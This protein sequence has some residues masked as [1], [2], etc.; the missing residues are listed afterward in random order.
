[1]DEIRQGLWFLEESLWDAA[2]DLVAVWQ[3]R[4]PGVPLRFGTWIGGDLDGNPNASAATVREAV[5][6]ASTVVRELLRR[7]VRALAASWGMSTTLVDA[8][9]AVGAV[10]L[11]EEANPT[12]PYR[13]RL[14]AI[15][16]RLGADGYATVEELRDELD[17]LETSLRGHGGARVADGGLADLR[18]R[19]DVF[20][21]TGPSLDVRIHARALRDDPDGIRDV[22]TE[23]AAVQRR[24]GR[25]AIDTLIV[26]MTRSADDVR[27]AERLA[28]E[29]GLEVEVVPLLETI[30]DLRGARALVE[31]LLDASPRHGFE[32]MVGYSDSGKDGGVVT[33]QWEIFQA[34]EN[35]AWLAGERGVEL[36]VF[37]GRGGSAGRGGG[38]THAAILAQPPHAVAGRL[39]LTE[40][41]E[42]IAFKYGLP[43]LARRNLEAAVAATLLTALPSRRR[44]RAARRARDDRGDLAGR[45]RGVSLDRLGRP[46]ASALPP[47]VH[48]ARRAR[49][50]EIGSRP[51]SRPGAAGPSE[52]ESLRAI[53]WVFAWTQTR[54]IVPA[55]LGAG[56]GLAAAPV[57][58]LRRLYDGW[59]FFQ[60]LVENLEMSLAKSSMEIAERYLQL[61]DDTGLAERVF[62]A[63]RAE[64]DLARGAVLEIVGP[65]G[66]PRPAP[67]APAVDPPSEP[68]CRPDERHPGRAAAAAPGRGR[69]GD[70]TAAPLDRR[71]RRS[72][73]EHGLSAHGRTAQ[74]RDSKHGRSCRYRPGEVRRHTRRLDGCGARGTRARG[75]DARPRGAP[76]GVRP[77]GA[78]RRGRRNRG[79]RHGGGPRAHACRSAPRGRPRRP[80]RAGLFA[81]GSAPLPPRGGDAGDPRRH[82]RC[83]RFHGRRDIARR[84]RD[85]RARDAARPPQARGCAPAAGGP[86]RR[87]AGILVL[88]VAMMR[89]PDL[90]PAVPEPRSLLALAVLAVGLAA[91]GLLVTR[92]MRTYRLT[93]RPL[94]LAVAVGVVWLGAALVGALIYDFRNL[95]W[96]LGHALEIAGIAAVGI[97]VALDLRRGAAQ[98]SGPLWGDLRGA[99]LVAAE[100][101]FLGSHV[102][103]LLVA[104]AEKDGS[105]EEHTR[106]VALLAVQ[107][108]EQLGLP[109]GRLR[110]LATGGLL[111]DIGKLVVPDSVLKKPAALTSDEFA[112]ITR[113]PTAG[114]ELLRELGGFD[115]QVQSLVHDHH[116]RLDGSGYPRR[117]SGTQIPL[118]R[119][120]PR[121]VRRLR[122]ADLTEGLP[123][124]LGSRP[125]D[126]APARRR[127]DALRPSLRRGS[128]AGARRRAQP[129]ARRRVG[130][131]AG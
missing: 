34:Q 106:R 27:I 35:L 122:R 4:L 12:E 84:V 29:V 15:W 85:P 123:R 105:T 13:R 50:L 80:R 33:A 109:P 3:A 10:D 121:R 92:A 39:K 89:W 73:A 28:A 129:R 83:R 26:S 37:H 54:C 11:P 116:E 36:T 114:V 70:A 78:L 103:A 32:V 130:P 88:G 7:D 59:P 30:D 24:R 113:H 55:W 60:A 17:V 49:L 131:R 1:M 19:L 127:R 22:L 125:G 25:R 124:G 97:P 65:A 77:L 66:A 72:A 51:V 20:G 91:C 44:R 57:D 8:D 99:D 5:E 90:V 68:V 112:S 53:P 48:P 74:R 93:R 128:R 16:E 9:A 82:E 87:S 101:A 2:A 45:A 79:G 126:R 81:D 98:R 61:V 120:D 52:L 47:V 102:R 41:G 110:S 95:G 115:S 31:A 62:A 40:Q 75:P 23:A 71:H 96:W 104:L 86:P 46:G 100:E 42:T 18:R 43:G 14:T 118:G 111:H 64:H 76:G 117:L 69:R 108:G 119:A 38:P 56:A 67:G 94:D 21:L 63:L 107:V 6:R 58:E